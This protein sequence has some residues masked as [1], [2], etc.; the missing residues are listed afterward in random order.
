VPPDTY[1]LA[2]WW[3][4]LCLTDTSLDFQCFLSPKIAPASQLRVER[5][6]K[7][8]TLAPTDLK[9]TPVADSMEVSFYLPVGGKKNDEDLVV[10]VHWL[11]DTAS[12]TL[13]EAGEWRFGRAANVPHPSGPPPAPP[14]APGGKNGKTEKKGSG[15]K[16]K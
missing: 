7:D 6:K 3:G 14:A 8:E 12:G 13:A 2:V 9:V 15:D 5:M 10:F 16:D 11:P 4:R 1:I